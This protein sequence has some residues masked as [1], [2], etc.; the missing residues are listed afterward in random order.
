ME[1]IHAIHKAVAE[2]RESK[3][4]TP[5]P[6]RYFYA[7]GTGIPDDMAVDFFKDNPSIIVVTRDGKK[8]RRGQDYSDA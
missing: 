2:L 3:P 8:W 5:S 6:Y 1:L 4:D 7:G